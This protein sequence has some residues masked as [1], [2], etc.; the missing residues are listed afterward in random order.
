MNVT[1]HVALLTTLLIY[2]AKA[3]PK[4]KGDFVVVFIA[5]EEGGEHGVGTSI[6]VQQLLEEDVTNILTP[7][8]EFTQASRRGFRRLRMR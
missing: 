1:G 7:R 3:K 8:L 2:L 4:L 5:A 6:F